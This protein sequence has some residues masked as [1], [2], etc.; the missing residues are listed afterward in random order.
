MKELFFKL[1]K[2]SIDDMDKFEQNEMKE[3]GFDWLIHYIPEPFR[4][5]VG[6]FKD[7]TVSLFKIN[8]PKKTGYGRGKKLSKPKTQNTRNPIYIKKEKK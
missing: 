7:K 8:T 1:I 4:K 2:V 3:D 6:G 5:C